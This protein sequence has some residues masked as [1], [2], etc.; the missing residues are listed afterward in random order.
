M[1]EIRLGRIEQLFNSLDH[2]PFLEKDLDEDAEEYIVG[3]MRELGRRET[4][5]LVLHL[6][7]EE[8]QRLHSAQEYRNAARLRSLDHEGEVCLE[9]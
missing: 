1:I 9:L 6:P 8:R 3:A 4:V 5:S 2:A 7:S